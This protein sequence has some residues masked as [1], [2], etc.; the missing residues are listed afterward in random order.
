MD[1]APIAVG[2]IRIF[3]YNPFRIESVQS[4]KRNIILYCLLYRA[5]LPLLK[6][7]ALLNNIRINI[8][9]LTAH[10]VCNNLV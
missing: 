6:G 5:A 2:D 9:K 10:F 3:K 4:T 7:H 1:N 8:R